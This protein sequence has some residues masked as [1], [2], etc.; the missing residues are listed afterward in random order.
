MLSTI[1]RMRYSFILLITAIALSMSSCYT[2]QDETDTITITELPTPETDTDLFGSLISPTGPLTQYDLVINDES[3]T[4]DE[5]YFY[6]KNLTVTKQ[7][8]LMEAYKDG[9]L[10]GIGM[11]N[12][13]EFDINKVE[14]TT[15]EN[16]KIP[17]SGADFLASSF[18]ASATGESIELRVPASSLTQTENVIAAIARVSSDRVAQAYGEAAYKYEPNTDE[19]S[20]LYLKPSAGFHINIEDNGG[21]SVLTEQ[22]AFELTFGPDLHGKSLFHYHRDF[23]YWIHI[24]DISTR[25]ISLASYGHYMIAEHEPGVYAEGKMEN[26]SRPLSF[27]RTNFALSNKNLYTTEKGRWGAVLPTEN[28]VE[29]RLIS[30]CGETISSLDQDVPLT[31]EIATSNIDLSSENYFSVKTSIFDCEGNSSNGSALQLSDNS[32]SDLYFFST[33]DLDLHLV[34]CDNSFEISSYDEVSDMQGPRIPWDTGYQDELGYLVNCSALEDGYTYLKVKDDEIILAPF[35]IEIT[36]GVTA[37][38]SQEEHIR[39]EFEGSEA[40]AYNMEDVSRIFIE[41]PE[42]GPLGYSMDCR[43]DLGCGLEDFRVTHFDAMA[44]GWFRVSFEGSLWMLTID[45]PQAGYVPVEGVILAR[46]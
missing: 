43:S 31:G 19:V 13:I 12:L 21:A 44:D 1:Y 46:R 16:L 33:S 3:Y 27:V 7:G 29:Q 15:V 22:S 38:S 20:Y 10:V 8:Q 37:L 14:M 30:P 18:R 35:S 25:A 9:D 39:I 6:L 36:D 28:T 40:Q 11:P 41:L 5:D 17:L 4:V 23:G 42:V 24:R 45:N 2:D 34:V 26:N 32:Q